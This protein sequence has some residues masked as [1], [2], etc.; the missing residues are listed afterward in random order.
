[1][2]DRG[3]A[4]EGLDGNADKIKRETRRTEPT[5]RD[6][7]AQ[8]N[9]GQ[10]EQV[11]RESR[12]AAAR[13]QEQGR[14]RPFAAASDIAKVARLPARTVSDARNSARRGR[15]VWIHDKTKVTGKILTPDDQK[16]LGGKKRAA[17]W[18][19]DFGPMKITKQAPRRQADYFA[20]ARK[21]A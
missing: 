8:A 19:L 20:V 1:L 14:R 15:R 6:G 3:S 7:L 10:G 16:R 18:Q 21:R 12:A 5:G 11:D 13:V 17:N 4:S 9:T 2:E